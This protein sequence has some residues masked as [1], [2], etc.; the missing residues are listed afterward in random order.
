MI[1]A[2]N[3]NAGEVVPTAAQFPDACLGL[4]QRFSRDAA[5]TANHFR[6]DDVELPFE[7]APAVRHF[8]RQRIAI[9]RRAAFEHVQNVNFFA[10]YPAGCDHLVEQLPRS[11]DKRFTLSINGNKLALGKRTR[12]FVDAAAASWAESHS[13]R[14]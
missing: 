11:T 5:K 7:K 12:P 1:R 8:V 6:F 3:R 13:S 10:L 9:L 2:H 4:Q 14:A